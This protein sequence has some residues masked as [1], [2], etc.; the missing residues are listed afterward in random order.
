[1]SRDYY[2]ILGVSR[3]AG[4]A[5]IRERFRQ[6]ARERH[7]DRFR[8][9]EKVKAE[10]DFQAVTEAFNV[11][12]DPERRRQYD[13]ELA[14]P[15]GKSQ[16]GQSGYDPQELAKVHMQR[17]VRA[18][19]EK[20]YLRAA[21]EFDAATRAAP[22]MAKAWYSLA[23]ACSREPRF[24]SR[25]GKAIAK[26]CELKP[27]NETYL[28]AAGRL[29]ARAGDMGKAEHYYTEALKWSADDPAIRKE[30][31]ELAGAKKSGKGFSL[32]GKS[33]G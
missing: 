7:P 20:N 8:G 9:E 6:I 25:A 27:M 2:S 11:L 16:S 4:A 13:A 33:S 29:F 14:S 22:E 15:G 12:N 26:A 5:V 19:K 32:F 18:Y 1:M 30:W 10:E 17:G 31:E 23:L 28:R 21:D 24:A 3:D